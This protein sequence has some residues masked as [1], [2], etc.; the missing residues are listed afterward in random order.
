MYRIKPWEI[1]GFRE[2]LK[3]SLKKEDKKEHTKQVNIKRKNEKVIH[4]KKT[5]CGK[6]KCKKKV[7]R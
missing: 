5:N 6:E 2:Q 7:R 4:Y 3:I 1:K